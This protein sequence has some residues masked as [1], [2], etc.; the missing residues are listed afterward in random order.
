MSLMTYAENGLVQDE[1][2]VNILLWNSLIEVPEEKYIFR[3]CYKKL[4]LDEGL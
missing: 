2:D 4:M 1:Q 3:L